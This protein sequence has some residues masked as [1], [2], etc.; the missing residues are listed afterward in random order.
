MG[1]VSIGAGSVAAVCAAGA[2]T[3]GL[4]FFPP[5]PM[6]VARAIT[7]TTAATPGISHLESGR[8]GSASCRGGWVGCASGFIGWV[9][10]ATGSVS[11]GLGGAGSLASCSTGSVS[12]TSSNDFASPCGWVSIC[13]SVSMLCG[14]SCGRIRIQSARMPNCACVSRGWQASVSS[15]VRS[16]AGG[17]RMPVQ[18]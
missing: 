18:Q 7:A 15:M 17:G 14:R 6:E 8:F 2:F 9:F 13:R 4:D 5:L 1:T 10:W 12:D 3:E 11:I 16:V